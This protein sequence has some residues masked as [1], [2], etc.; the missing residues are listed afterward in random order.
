[1]KHCSCLDFPPLMR[2]KCETTTNSMQHSPS[3]EANS[4]S[5][6]QKIPRILWKPKVLRHVHNSPPIV[7]FL[8]QINPEHSSPHDVPRRS[9][10]ILSIHLHL[11]VPSCCFPSGFPTKTLNSTLF[12]CVPHVPPI[13]FLLNIYIYI[14]IQICML[15]KHNYFTLTCA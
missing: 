6:S 11:C 12:S 10:L 2:R 3:G 8:S 4:F 9:T 13:T 15:K 14:S 5:A 1:M 7:S